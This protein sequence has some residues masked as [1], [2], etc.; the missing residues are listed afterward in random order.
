LPKGLDDTP[1]LVGKPILELFPGAYPRNPCGTGYLVEE[2]AQYLDGLTLPQLED[3]ASLLRP[4]TFLLRDPTQWWR[5]PAP[6]GFGWCNALW[7]PRILHTGGRPYYLPP[8]SA[9]AAPAATRE[10][11]GDDLLPSPEPGEP[12]PSLALT[13]EAAPE[14][15]L[16]YLD[17]DETI[18]LTGFGTRDPQRFRL[19]RERPKVQAQADGIELAELECRIHTL[20]VDADKGEFYVLYSNRFEIP[21]DLAADLSAGLVRADV[22]ARCHVR[23]DGYPLGPEDWPAVGEERD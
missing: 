8:P 14:L 19:P 1:L 13:N 18:G 12:S 3:P 22:L 7:Y 5:C 10:P 15:V 4:E 23:V 2:T 11:E 17:G 6:A 9:A 21:D 16:P 20:A